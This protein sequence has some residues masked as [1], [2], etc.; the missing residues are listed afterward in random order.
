MDR[1]RRIISAK[2]KDLREQ[3]RWTQAEL[4]KRL[5]LSQ[6]RLSEL[7]R[8]QGSFTAEQLLTILALF[9]VS[10]S[11]FSAH[12]RPSA[13]IQNALARFGANHLA[14]SED[15]LP[16]DRFDQ[17][18]NLV[19]EV[20]AAAQSPRHIT[21]LAP[22]LI[23]NIN[24]VSLKKLE[25]QFIEI[26]LQRRFAWLVANT[27]EAIRAEL[28]RELARKWAILYR[29]AEVVLA[30]FLNEPARSRHSAARR[31]QS[32]RATRA[33]D[34]LDPD[35]ASTKTLR[36]VQGS[37]S[38]ISQRWGIATAIKP[39]DFIEALRAARAAD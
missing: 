28:S 22:V 23:R 9:N 4:S 36:E 24:N 16:S 31:S 21:S 30:A 6:S 35:I 18:A 20:L 8:G 26:G 34:I 37:L 14:E 32:R 10:V 29:R 27:L 38:P 7:E 25:A 2:V 39:E 5:G 33:L 13:Q 3:R 12:K 11:E 15:I 19:R 1:Q 17:V